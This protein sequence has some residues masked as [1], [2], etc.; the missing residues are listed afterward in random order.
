MDQ[1]NLCVDIFSSMSNLL[2]NF[3][4]NLLNN[5]PGTFSHD[6]GFVN[7]QE[8]QQENTPFSYE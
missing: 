2:A 3:N 8:S 4:A 6:Q 1:P 7:R 5:N